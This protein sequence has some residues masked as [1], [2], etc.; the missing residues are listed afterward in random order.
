LQI[1]K[2]YQK[3]LHPHILII[4]NYSICCQTHEIVAKI[5]NEC[6]INSLFDNFLQT[7]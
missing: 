4:I 6:T 7:S 2:P 3:Q 5:I 1:N